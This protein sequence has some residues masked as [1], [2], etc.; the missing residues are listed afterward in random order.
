MKIT[1]LE[2]LKIHRVL[3]SLAAKDGISVLEV[4]LSIQQ[5]IDE[6]WALSRS[7]PAAKAHWDK[8]FPDGKKPSVDAFICRL[9]QEMSAGNN[10]PYLLK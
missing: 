7:D 10:P 8:L 1:F 5:S 4:R 2:H 6:A 9:G 3:R